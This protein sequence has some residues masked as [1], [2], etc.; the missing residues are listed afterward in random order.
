MQQDVRV[1]GVR[2]GGLGAGQSTLAKT[3]KTGRAKQKSVGEQGAHDSLRHRLKGSRSRLSAPPLVTQG[4]K[5]PSSEVAIG[6]GS[7]RSSV[8]GRMQ[9][10]PVSEWDSSDQ[11]AAAS[12]S[13]GRAPSQTAITSRISVLADLDTSPR[14]GAGHELSRTDSAEY[15][16]QFP[17]HRILAGCSAS[18]CA[19]DTPAPAA[20]LPLKCV[21]RAQL[22]GRQA[23][24][25]PTVQPR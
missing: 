18:P 25:R 22:P 2:P 11:V 5:R 14:Q 3:S 17:Q 20:P 1:P 4:R 24:P 21:P 7:R 23:A 15:G 9:D 16:M 10:H 12:A 6:W 8:D 13:S 19:A